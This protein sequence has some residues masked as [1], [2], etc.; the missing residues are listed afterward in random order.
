MG[1]INNCQTWPP[2]VVFITGAAGGIGRALSFALGAQGS[3]IAAL[4]VQAAGLASL[5]RELTQRNVRAD[6]EQADVTDAPA[7]EQKVAV[8][9]ERLG[10]AD[11]LIAGAGI[12]LETPAADFVSQNLAKII[13]VNLL[14]VAN[15]I[16]AVLPGML[17]RRR[18]HIAVISSLAAMHGM[19]RM[20]GYCASKAGINALLEG[21]RLELKPHQIAVT[22]IC[23][24]WVRTPMTQ[25]VRGAMPGLIEADD[26][27][28]RIVAALRRRTPFFAFPSPAAWAQRILSWLPS[29][30]GDLVIESMLRTQGGFWRCNG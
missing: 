18:G 10:P 7:L 17:R 30:L 25:S 29:G 12:S 27:A 28:R 26:A 3:A 14:G 21:L 5:Q 19:P 22:T 6:G 11:L 1:S 24:S 20:F 13:Q 23:P 2:R 4:D 15:S 16:A 8:L 9:E